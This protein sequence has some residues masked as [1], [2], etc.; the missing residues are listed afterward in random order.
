MTN[1]DNCKFTLS[2]KSSFNLVHVIFS[3]LDTVSVFLIGEGVEYGKNSSDQFDIGKQVG[4]FLESGGEIVACGTCMAIR[5]QRS[6]KEC[7]E[8]GMEDLYSLIVNSDKV[9]TF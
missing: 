3:I 1:N 9:I 8:G 4:K 7:P 6:S 2:F 5:K